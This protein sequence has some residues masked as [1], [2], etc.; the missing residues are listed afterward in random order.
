MIGPP[1]VKLA[2]TIV[3]LR[4]LPRE[5]TPYLQKT[6]SLRRLPN[7]MC[8]L[9]RSLQHLSLQNRTFIVQYGL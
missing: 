4:Y 2:W 9:S 6:M 7:G 8:D 1:V 3:D 5:G